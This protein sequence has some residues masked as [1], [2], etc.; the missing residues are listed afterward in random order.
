MTTIYSRGGESDLTG[1]AL[2]DTELDAALVAADTELL[3]HVKSRAHPQEAL[4]AMMASQ[5]ST[6][7]C[8]RSGRLITSGA[9]AAR[10]AA[11]IEMR[12][13]ARR[14]CDSLAR[15]RLLGETV[16]MALYAALELPRHLN[17]CY[18]T[19]HPDEVVVGQPGPCGL[20][21]LL[22]RAKGPIT[23]LAGQLDRVDLDALAKELAEVRDQADELAAMANMCCSGTDIPAKSAALADTLDCLGWSGLRLLRALPRVHCM[24]VELRELAD[25]DAAVRLGQPG[26]DCQIKVLYQLNYLTETVAAVHRDAEIVMTAIDTAVH[27]HPGRLLSKVEIDVSGADLSSVRLDDLAVL[28]GVLWTP[29]TRWPPGTSQAIQDISDKVGSDCYRVGTDNADHHFELRRLVTA[30]H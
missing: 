5:G 28:D 25:A 20:G 26:S 16:A 13:I 9:A 11:I 12:S 18:P 19:R 6:A 3:E 8:A 7:E 15:A 29:E 23:Y 27:Q 17:P 24:A 22:D 21:R 14:L 4:L 10:A 1:D 2:T 30:Q